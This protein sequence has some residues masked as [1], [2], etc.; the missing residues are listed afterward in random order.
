MA[1]G[2]L[3]AQSFQVYVLS[4]VTF[5]NDVNTECDSVSWNVW[6]WLSKPTF[7]TQLREQLNSLTRQVNDVIRAAAQD[8][9]RMGVIFVDGLEEVYNGHRYCEPGLTDQKMVSY[10]TWFWSPDS[11]MTPPSEGPDDPNN[12]S[13]ADDDTDPAQILLD[14]IFPGE[15]YT[16]DHPP[17]TSPPWEWEGAA[18]KYPT[19]DDLL[20][21]VAL[22]D[23]VNTASAPFNYLRSFHPKATAYGEHKRLLFAAIANNRDF[24]VASGNTGSNYTQR[25]KDVSSHFD[26]KRQSAP[27]RRHNSAN[28]VEGHS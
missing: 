9:E 15:N 27:R 11:K 8:L 7:T 16:V 25:C 19:F 20:E 4:Y 3:P 18:Q 24:P 26:L 6:P 22:A 13:T 23:D 14:F 2:A 5:F 17:S 1:G 12:P 10:H 28:L 21:S